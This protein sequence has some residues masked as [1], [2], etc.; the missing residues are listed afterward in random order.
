LCYLLRNPGRLVTR[1]ELYEAVWP[2][3]IVSENSISQCIRELRCILGDADG[4]LIK[5]LA[6]RGYLLDA[7]V[8]RATALRPPDDLRPPEDLHP[9]DDLAVVPNEAQPVTPAASQSASL[10]GGILARLQQRPPEQRP[11]GA[12]AIAVLVCMVCVIFLLAWGKP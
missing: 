6:R 10:K 4:K 7:T 9:P 1:Q 5:T 11:L 12:A 3:V 8:S 2:D